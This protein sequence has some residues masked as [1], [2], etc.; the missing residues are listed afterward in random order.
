MA[1]AALGVLAALLLA[2][3]V[4]LAWR[5]RVLGDVVARLQLETTALARGLTAERDRLQAALG[6]DSDG[7]FAVDRDGAVRYLNPAAARLLRAGA[8]ALDHSAIVL[9][10][11]HEAQAA[12]TAALADREPRAALLRPGGSGERTLRLTVVPVERAGDWSAIAFLRDVTDVLRLETVRRDFVSNVSH[13][14][15]TPLASIKAVVETLAMGA[16][17]E[18][19][20]ARDFLTSID[21]EVDRL[22]LLVQELL[23]LGRIESDPSAYQFAVLDPGDLI[24]ACVRRMGPQAERAGVTLRAE[25]TTT[26]PIRGDRERLERAL[27]NLIHNALKFTPRDGAVAVRA[28]ETAATVELVVQ[29]TGLGIAPE[30]LDRIFERFYT[31][32]RARSGGGSGLGLAI[33]KHIAEAHDGGVTVTSAL[34][35]GSTFTLTLP[36]PAAGH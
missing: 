1:V 21:E 30:H 10:R 32:D 29:D 14:L 16:L 20:V 13:E 4:V 5:V 28:R 11:D 23:E 12:L 27:L 3:A 25:V 15:R 26:A 7:A 17:E 31:V 22:T 36:R 19:E 33:V 35:R 8:A 18:P 34:G 6:A 24:E 2:V 9:L